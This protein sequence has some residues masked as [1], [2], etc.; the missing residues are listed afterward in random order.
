M[1]AHDPSSAADWLARRRRLDSLLRLHAAV[2]GGDAEH[3]EAIRTL[4]EALADPE[5]E[6]RELASAALSD[7]GPDAKLA[8][9]ELIQAVQDENAVVRRRALRA[10]AFIGPAAADDALA[11]L[12]AATEDVD[13]SVGLQA[14]ATIG[15]LGPGAAP[16]VPALMSAVW[17]G[18]V[19]RRAVA[20]VALTHVG[21]AAVPSLM[22]SLSHPAAEVR[23][24]VI[25]L[26]GQIGPN[27]AEARGALRSLLDDADPAVRVEAASALSAIG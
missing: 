23:V 5:A 15:E 10:I 27:A 18:D 20:G 16:A 17:T 19:R 8:L 1:A 4:A 14:V 6:V 2:I 3:A 9:P 25:H 24:K 26:L 11:C 13:D 7:F 21:A 12:I 22:Q